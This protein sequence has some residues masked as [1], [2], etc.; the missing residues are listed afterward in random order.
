MHF[1]FFFF[2]QHF[3]LV[4]FRTAWDSN[5]RRSTKASSTLVSFY[6]SVPSFSNQ[7][8][9][10]LFLSL[11]IVE[12]FRRFILASLENA[13]SKMVPFVREAHESA[14]LTDTILELDAICQTCLTNHVENRASRRQ[15]Y[16]TFMN[17]I[18]LRIRNLTFDWITKSVCTC[19]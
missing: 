7:L 5:Q 18:I 6:I 10:V 13:A 14:D 15:V 9:L 1:F 8:S 11:K 2:F 19:I 12:S 4:A 3:Q 16:N 17:F